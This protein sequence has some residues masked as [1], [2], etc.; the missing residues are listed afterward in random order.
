VPAFPTMAN[1][2]LMAPRL[3]RSSGNQKRA[4]SPPF[5]S[6]YGKLARH[7]FI[8]KDR[9]RF[10]DTKGWAYAVFDYNPASDKFRPNATGIVNYGY[11][12]HTIVAK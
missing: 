1:L 12:C 11:A 4:R 5:Q 7:F 2:S 9:K 10:P 8:E 6:V 3:Q